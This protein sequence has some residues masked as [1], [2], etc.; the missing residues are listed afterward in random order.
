MH[1]AHHRFTHLKS[2]LKQIPLHFAL[3]FY[4]YSGQLTHLGELFNVATSTETF[5]GTTQ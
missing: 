4:L 3:G 1:G 2:G 5:A